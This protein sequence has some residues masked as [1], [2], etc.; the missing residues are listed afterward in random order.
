LLSKAKNPDEILRI[1]QKYGQNEIL[2]ILQ[3]YGTIP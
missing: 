2:R 1:L 3:N